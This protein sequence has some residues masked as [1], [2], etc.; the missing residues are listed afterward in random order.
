V[1]FRHALPKPERTQDNPPVTTSANIEQPPALN[2]DCGAARCRLN[3]I[4]GLD[5]RGCCLG[6]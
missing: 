3:T 6:P 4:A 5:R 2:L 1:K